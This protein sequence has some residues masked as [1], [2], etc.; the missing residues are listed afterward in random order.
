MTIELDAGLVDRVATGK[1]V[2]FLGAGASIGA[3]R[4]D[5]SGIPDAGELGR[6]IATKFL[7]P[8]YDNADF[9]TICDFAA[10]ARSGREVQEFIHDQLEKFAPAPFHLLIPKFAWSGLA[11]TN[12]DLVLEDAYEAAANRIQELIPNCKDG[13]GAP[14]RLGSKGVL[15]VKLH[16]CITHYQEVHPPMIASTEQIIHHREGRAG[17]FAQFL[18]WA[19]TRTIIFAGYGLGDFNLRVLIDEMRKDGDG[20]P[21]HY[22]VRPNIKEVESDYWRQRRARTISATFED[23]LISLDAQVKS[24]G[25]QL[26]L[27]PVTFAGT[28]FT[29]FISKAGASESSMLL[30]YLASEC[31]HVSKHSEGALATPAKFYRGFDLGWYPI[32][33]D[34]DVQRRATQILM[35]ER[36]VANQGIVKPQFVILKGHAGSGKSVTLRRL[37]WDAAVKGDCLV[38]RLESPA[39]LSKDAFDE[40]FQLTKQTVF[41]VVDNVT[42]D[43]SALASFYRYA[44]SQKWPL[45]VVAGARVNEWNI[46]CE[47]LESLLDEEYELRYLSEREIESLL[48]LLE[49]HGCLGYLASLPP[50]ERRRKLREVYSR[51]LLVALHEATENASFRDIIVNEFDQIFPIEA[52]LL[53]L[54]IC[55]LHRFGPPVRAGLIARVHGIDFDEFNARFFKPLEEVIKLERDPKTQDWV[56]RARHTVIA[57]IVYETCLKT[58]QEKYDNIIRVITRLNPAYSY[59]TEVLSELI[60][61][62]KLCEIFRDRILGDD[63][64][65]LAV[66]LVGDVP[67]VYHQRGIYE[68]R[69][70]GDRGG[71]DRAQRYL[72]RALELAPSNPTIKHSM[73]ELALKRS[74]IAEEVEERESW[75]RRADAQA[76]VLRKNSRTSHPVHTMAKVAL[77]RV[78]D[79]VSRNEASDDVRRKRRSM[80]QLRTLKSFS[81]A[82]CSS[83]LMMTDS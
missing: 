41:L 11:T 22:I 13:D 6:R 73:A 27:H 74:S 34:L 24:T 1:A 75:R 23:L 31:E 78:R 46:R 30:R 67:F 44:Q 5:G 71:L 48:A 79:A 7:G 12:Y 43:P 15:Y 29:R 62:S 58:V 65:R 18:E 39:G 14:E 8:G 60:R 61:A 80:R 3:K 70:A 17:Q 45:V 72:E 26:A 54:D 68:M 32:T 21:W 16:G 35:D 19:R 77:A 42:E 52:R 63:I 36:I 47:E 28:S 40:I 56:Y 81:A 57:D 64:Y 69:L 37:A 2:L 83:F 33:N 59:D 49:R 10:S 9:K 20:H 25:R 66:E 50:E 38:F 76:S 4:T 82:A 53:Y 51:Q 55:S